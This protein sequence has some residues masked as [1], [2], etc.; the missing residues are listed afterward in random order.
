M[1]R[2][3][4]FTKADKIFVKAALSQQSSYWLLQMAGDNSDRPRPSAPS[5]DRP[6]HRHKSPTIAVCKVLSITGHYLSHRCIQSHLGVPG[7]GGHDKSGCW[8]QLGQCVTAT[9]L[10]H[11]DFCLD[12]CPH[13]LC[14]DIEN[15][16]FLLFPY[17]PCRDCPKVKTPF[18]VSITRQL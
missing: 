5:L 1:I 15:L 17:P 13:C 12:L 10:S 4:I 2:V 9:R 3:F 8:E 14:L 7:I 6:Q 18:C 16:Q 11:L